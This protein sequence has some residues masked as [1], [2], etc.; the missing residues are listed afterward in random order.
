MQPIKPVYTGQIYDP[1]QDVM[2]TVYIKS[3]S[4]PLI[5]QLTSGFEIDKLRVAMEKLED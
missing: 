3:S 4:F 1:K 2:R 5:P